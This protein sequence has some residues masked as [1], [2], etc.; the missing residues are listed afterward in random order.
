MLHVKQGLVD[1]FWTSVLMSAGP[2]AERPSQRMKT[3]RYPRRVLRAALDPVG[4]S[5]QWG[6]VRRAFR[7]ALLFCRVPKIS[8]C[9]AILYW[10]SSSLF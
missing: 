10:I 8:V 9:G 6:A 7:T 4:K 3:S 2:S 5:E 1:I